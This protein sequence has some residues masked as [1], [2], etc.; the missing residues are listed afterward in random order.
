VI[1]RLLAQDLKA[2]GVVMAG[3]ESANTIRVTLSESNVGRLW[4]AEIGEGNA[5]Q[6]A[7]VQ[8][9]IASLSRPSQIGQDPILLRKVA[10]LSHFSFSRGL[11]FVSDDAVLATIDPFFPIALYPDKLEF[12]VFS[13]GLGLQEDSSIAIRQDRSL[14]RDPRGLLILS[15]DKN[16]FSAFLPGM[17]C[18]GSRADQS[19]PAKHAADTWK[20]DCHASD[21]PWPIVVDATG[22]AQLK[23][24]YNSARDY[25]TGV[26]S[27]SVGVDLPPFY[28]AAL[29][30]RSVGSGALLIG[31]IDGRVQ[32][33]ENGALKVVTGT[34][35]WGSD[36]AVLHSGCGAGVQVI[37]SSSGEATNDSLRAYELPALEA[38]T[39]SA[40]LAMGG[41]VTA[42]WTAPGGT[43]W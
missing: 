34:R 35:D 5:T 28:E 6:V 27:P 17:A 22:A 3:A 31:G 43:R 42:L 21:E 30:P 26:V 24:F 32:L 29:V 37:A 23:A 11:P 1:R 36:F 16:S 18:A 15:A 33:A 20:F 2:H 9:D 4:V 39:A 40:P 25:F 7:M 8:A 10:Y 14:P 41:T 19:A 38:V 12:F 13:E